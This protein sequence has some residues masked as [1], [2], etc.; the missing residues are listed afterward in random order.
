MKKMGEK[1]N[2]RRKYLSWGD[3]SFFRENLRSPA[4]APGLPQS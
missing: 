2:E 4:T 1:I 3:G